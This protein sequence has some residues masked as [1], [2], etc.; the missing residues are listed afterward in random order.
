MDNMNEMQFF[1]IYLGGLDG[2]VYVAGAA[3]VTAVERHLI[4]VLEDDATF[5]VL[6]AKNQA[7]A[8]VDMTAGGT[9]NLGARTYN[10]GDL[11]YAPYGGY[12][13]AYTCDKNTQHYSIPTT[14]RKRNKT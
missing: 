12:I 3:A 7:D 11:V 14:D 1:S 10:T 5:S 9:N 13:S 2:G 6:T 4:E 8:T